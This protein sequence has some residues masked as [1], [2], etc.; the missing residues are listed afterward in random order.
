MATATTDSVN[1]LPQDPAAA[2][3]EHRLP[4]VG[5]HEIEGGIDLWGVPPQPDYGDGWHEGEYRAITLLSAIAG[6]RYRAPDILRRVALDQ[7]MAGLPT[8]G[9]K[10]A[11]LGFWNTVLQL[12]IPCLNPENV[13]RLAV[14]LAAERC[15]SLAS[16]TRDAIE[17]KAEYRRIA[18]KAAAS[19]KAKAGKAVR[20]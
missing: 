1:S 4:F 10:G 14:N 15:G 17:L 20:P 16:S 2:H 8:P 5:R 3:P 12:I 18:L 19:R 13:G 7:V 6:N 9:H 11:V